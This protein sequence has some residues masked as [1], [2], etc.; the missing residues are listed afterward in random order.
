VLDAD[1]VQFVVDGTNVI[2]DMATTIHRIF[3]AG[4]PATCN[5]D[6]CENARNAV[7]S[8]KALLEDPE[9]ELDPREALKAMM[10]GALAGIRQ[11]D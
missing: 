9:A 5:E 4:D 10:T 1:A 3:H 2:V 8:A 7:R 6:E 11:S